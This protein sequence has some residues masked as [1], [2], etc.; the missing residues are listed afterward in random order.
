MMKNKDTEPNYIGWVEEPVYAADGNL[1]AWTIK[2]KK[3]DL[4]N[5]EV[6]AT[7]VNEQG[8]GGNIFLQLRMSKGGK[9]YGQV[10][11]PNSRSSQEKLSQKQA[12][13]EVASGNDDGLPF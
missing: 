4:K 5:L 13:A 3:A 8:Q 10:W 2:L 7:P 12:H 9:P 11:D 1:M 6:F